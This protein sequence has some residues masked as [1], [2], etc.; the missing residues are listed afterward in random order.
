MR[1]W[2]DGV[3]RRG[4]RRIAIRL[5]LPIAVALMASAPA[6][7][8]TGQAT[9]IC[10]GTGVNLIISMVYVVGGIS[11]AVVLMSMMAGAGL[12]SLGWVGRKIR[13]MGSRAMLGGLAGM[14][15]LTIVL[16]V[17]GLAY[18]GIGINIPSACMIPF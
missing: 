15:L 3:V 11:M 18:A 17:A 5:S 14:I 16:T 1:E 8:Q 12:I 9:E 2:F 10:N 6:A 13:G 4:G 7:A